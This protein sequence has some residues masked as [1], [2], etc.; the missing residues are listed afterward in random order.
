VEILAAVMSSDIVVQYEAPFRAAGFHPG[1]VT[2][3]SLAALN[4]LAP[5]GI[6]LLVKLS[7]RV[8]SVLVLQDNAVNLARC[9]EMEGGRLDDIES[10]LHPTI[11]YIEDELKSRPKQIWLA[12]FGAGDGATGAALGKRVGCRRAGHPLAF[13][14]AQR[15][16]PVCSDTWS[17][18]HNL[19]WLCEYPSI[20]RASRSGGTGRCWWARR[21]W[22][23]CSACC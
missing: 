18:W 9:I 19:A 23:S 3:S 2:T 8:L 6:T 10:V 4:L 21:R 13:S 1:L 14:A 7:G 22:P 5:D 11:A 16:T 20:L 12:G 15:A 17:R